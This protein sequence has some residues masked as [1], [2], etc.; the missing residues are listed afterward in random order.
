MT[1][2][3]IVLLQI[4]FFWTRVVLVAQKAHD[5]KMSQNRWKKV[6]RRQK[7][8]RDMELEVLKEEGMSKAR[9]NRQIRFKMFQRKFSHICLILQDTERLLAP[10]QDCGD[11]VIQI[12][13]VNHFINSIS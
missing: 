11:A 8:A 5:T 1:S 4:M 3:A 2:F 9:I 12:M 6:D 7:A 13:K 10:Q